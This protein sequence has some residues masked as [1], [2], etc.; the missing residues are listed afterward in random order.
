MRDILLAA[1]SRDGCSSN[2]GGQQINV[3][4]LCLWHELRVAR[5]WRAKPIMRAPQCPNPHALSEVETLL[6]T[7]PPLVFAGEARALESKIVRLVVRQPGGTIM[8]ENAQPGYR[9]MV[10]VQRNARLRPQQSLRSLL[11]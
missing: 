6:A 9:V 5:S 4:T 1:N 11:S 3:A 2:G 10:E 8:R 7:F